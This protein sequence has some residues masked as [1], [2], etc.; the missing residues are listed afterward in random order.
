MSKA[1]R[2]GSLWFGRV[3]IQ[4]RLLNFLE[5]SVREAQQR[6]TRSA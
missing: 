4:G 2:I 1:I 3:S 5:R 6:P